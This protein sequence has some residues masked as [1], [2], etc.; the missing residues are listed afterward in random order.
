[1]MWLS[2]QT[3]LFLIGYYN[4][5]C[6]VDI[7]LSGK[8]IQYV[9]IFIINDSMQFVT[10]LSIFEIFNFMYFLAILMNC[11][12][13]SFDSTTLRS[14]FLESPSKVQPKS[15]LIKKVVLD[16]THNISLQTWLKTQICEIDVRTPPNKTLVEDPQDLSRFL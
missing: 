14:P 3:A 11:G 10:F 7:V 5:Y 6:S 2:R 4:N 15:F 12:S 1:M 9:C 13:A 8:L 16:I